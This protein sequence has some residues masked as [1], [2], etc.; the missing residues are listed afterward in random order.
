MRPVGSRH[1][2]SSRGQESMTDDHDH[3][4]G[5][6]LPFGFDYE[7]TSCT[8]APL[9]GRSSAGVR[10][11]IS[12]ERARFLAVK[13]DSEL[14]QS[15]DLSRLWLELCRGTWF[16]RDTFSTDNRCFAWLEPVSL[17]PPRPLNACRLHIL[18]RLLLGDAPKVVAIE[19][20]KAIS[21]VATA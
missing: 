4:H 9:N 2:N 10:P 14:A 16:F 1:V 7:T 19:L 6:A 11:G 15:F 21:S 3:E 20:E 8:R 18:E 13:R 5:S 17:L 12:R